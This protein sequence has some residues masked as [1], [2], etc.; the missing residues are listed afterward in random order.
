MA[1]IF[2]R[3]RRPSRILLLAIGLLGLLCMAK[4]GFA[5]TAAELEETA[6]LAPP[7]EDPE[8]ERIKRLSEEDAVWFD[9]D[10]N[11]VL[12]D[13][14]VCLRQGQL[15][16]FACPATTKEHESIVA[17][18][19]S[20]ATVH[21]AL[22]AAGAISGNTVQFRPEY[23]PASGTEI[24]V[25]V[26]WVDDEGDRHSVPAQQW[27]RRAATGE[28]MDTPWVFAG[29]VFTKDSETGKLQ[30]GAEAGD[31][32]CVS[33]FPTATLD[34]PIESTELDNNLLFEAFTE[35]IPPVDTPVRLVLVPVHA[36]EES[37][38]SGDSGE[39]ASAADEANAARD[40]ASDEE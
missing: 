28:S 38:Q 23:I 8:G 10:N 34:L 35:N 6:D 3:L 19:T 15:E 7:G 11:I 2:R 39:G 36:G 31:L 40:A 17:V 25:L 32:I 20:A 16:M 12:V 33:N 27:V 21:A 24:R 30:Y 37:D 9:A 22:L 18:D 14:V 26:L 4:G 5:Q 13:G 29:S 1:V